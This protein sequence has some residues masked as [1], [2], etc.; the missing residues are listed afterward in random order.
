MGGVQWQAQ[1]PAAVFRWATSN[2]HYRLDVDTMDD[3]AMLAARTG[4]R[5]VW[6]ADLA[7]E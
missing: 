4:V 1:H 2:S 3:V 7:K 5:L 6:P